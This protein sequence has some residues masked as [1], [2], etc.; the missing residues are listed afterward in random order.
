M[1][2]LYIAPVYIDKNKPDGVGKKI[3][4]HIRVFQKSF[5]TTV[6][7]YGENCIEK[8]DKNGCDKIEIHGGHRR[9]ALYE[10]V[11][12]IANVHHFDSVYIRYP[13]S[14]AKFIS[15]LKCLHAK[16]CKV[17]I[18][19]PTYPY[20]GNLR[21]GLKVLAIAAVDYIYRSQIHKYVDRIVTYSDDEII[22][23]VPTIK[24]INGISFDS[25]GI[26][27]YIGNNTEI[28]LISVATN[29][30]C[31]GFDRIILGL[32]QYYAKPKEINVNFHIIG[33]GPAIETYKKMIDG[34]PELKAHIFLD[35]F[36]SGEKL[37]EQYGYADIAVNS[38]ALYRLGLKKEST[39]KTKEYAAKGLPIISSTFVDALTQ[40][41]NRKFVL[42]VDDCNA[43]I[44]IQDIIEFYNSI[45]HNAS[46]EDVAREIR[47]EAKDVCDMSVTLSE[48]VEYLRGEK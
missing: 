23:G 45:Y 16:G 30:E 35:G 37:E 14:D 13:K 28:N 38:L 9:Y 12:K 26:N 39:L 24:T 15:V 33:N 21:D 6:L 27:H 34:T 36:L 48:V 47:S 40:N 32:K 3:Y 29:Y 20:N 11:K 10:E 7:Y 8:K 18:E 2:L 22:F 43:P 19:I 41:G 31:H 1:K 46:H 44:K 5:D 25:V 42:K 17:V 4:N